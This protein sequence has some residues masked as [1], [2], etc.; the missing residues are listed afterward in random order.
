[1]LKSRWLLP[2]LVRG[3]A[4]P[5]ARDRQLLI[6]PVSQASPDALKGPAFDASGLFAWVWP[7]NTLRRASAQCPSMVEARVKSPPV[8]KVSPPFCTSESTLLISRY[9]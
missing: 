1:M 6:S 2:K 7:M 3:K 5:S 9:H 8:T 4:T